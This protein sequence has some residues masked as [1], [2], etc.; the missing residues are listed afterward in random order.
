MGSKSPSLTM[1]DFGVS[2]N[3]SGSRWW[4]PNVILL[5]DS[6]AKNRQ[7]NNKSKREEEPPKDVYILLFFCSFVLGLNESH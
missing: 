3:R 2:S 6:Y 4:S 1:E 5:L 7:V